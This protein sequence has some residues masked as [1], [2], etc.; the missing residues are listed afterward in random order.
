MN[1]SIAYEDHPSDHDCKDQMQ[2]ILLDDMTWDDRHVDVHKL[3]TQKLTMV[4]LFDWLT[5]WLFTCKSLHSVKYMN[6]LSNAHHHISSR[7]NKSAL[8]FRPHNLQHM[9]ETSN[10]KL[11][12]PNSSINFF[13]RPK[14]I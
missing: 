3:S 4:D 10:W 13:D 11:F 6:K 2:G 12:Q 8:T 5:D 1:I 14:N 7:L 9:V